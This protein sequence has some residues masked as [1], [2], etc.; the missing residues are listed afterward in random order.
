MRKNNEDE[1][2]SFIRQ[3]ISQK[4]YEEIGGGYTFEV[5]GDAV[6]KLL[7]QLNFTGDP[8]YG[9]SKSRKEVEHISD[10]SFVENYVEQRLSESLNNWRVCIPRGNRKKK[11]VEILL[12]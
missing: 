5:A 9:S 2:I 6:L 12:K 1:I 10:Q 8:N 7:R 11:S 4:T 3:N